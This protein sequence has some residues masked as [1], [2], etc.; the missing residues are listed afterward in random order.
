MARP[1]IFAFFS[2]LQA[3]GAFCGAWPASSDRIRVDGTGLA[4]R[5]LILQSTRD[6]ATPAAGGPVM[7]AALNGTLVWVDGTD[8][9]SFGRGNAPVDDAVVRYLE[10]GD[11]A[12]T[13]APAAAITTPNPPTEVPG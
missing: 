10:S 8:H 12:V 1:G 13:S 6:T 9:G 2:R 7:A 3:S 11:V 4:T 5:P